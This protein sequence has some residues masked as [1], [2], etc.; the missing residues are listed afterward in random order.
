M[1]QERKYPLQHRVQLAPEELA[2]ASVGGQ[3]WGAS[4][5]S[6]TPEIYFMSLCAGKAGLAL[7][8]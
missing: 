2:A 6:L 1:D 3:W 5:T 4:W 7:R 8:E